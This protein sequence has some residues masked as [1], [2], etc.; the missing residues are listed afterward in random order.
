[1]GDYFFDRWS[2]QLIEDTTGYYSGSIYSEGTMVMN[3]FIGEYDD[4]R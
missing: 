3:G 1:M 4:P 2:R